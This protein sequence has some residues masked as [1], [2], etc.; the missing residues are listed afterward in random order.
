MCVNLDPRITRHVCGSGPNVSDPR[1]VPLVS[2]A[3]GCTH[4]LCAGS[5][6]RVDGL[7]GSGGGFGK[8]LCGTTTRLL[9]TLSQ[10]L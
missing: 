2:H 8:R 7:E 3:T 9:A 4:V 6:P 10:A 1:F 5:M